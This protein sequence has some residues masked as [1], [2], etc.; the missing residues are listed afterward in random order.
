MGLLEG[1]RWKG[2]VRGLQ[3]FLVEVVD[4]RSVFPDFCSP[5]ETF[6]AQAPAGATPEELPPPPPVVK[7]PPVPSPEPAKPAPEPDDEEE[8]EEDDEDLLWHLGPYYHEF[9]SQP[10]PTP[11]RK[12]PPLRNKGLGPGL[13]K[14]HQWLLSPY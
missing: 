14:G 7:P 9:A 6:L 2:G 5:L 8:E 10:V 13:I 12:Y 3:K 1:W 11:Q 4:F